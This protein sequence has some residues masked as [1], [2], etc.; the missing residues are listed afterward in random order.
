LACGQG[1]EVIDFNALFD[2]IDTD[3]DLDALRIDIADAIAHGL[4]ETRDEFGYWEKIHFAQAI[5]AF[6]WNI[7]SGRDSTSWLRLC[8]VNLERAFAPRDGRIEDYAPRNAQIETLTFEQ[9]MD[10]VRTLGGHV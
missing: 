7:N 8:L 6:A 5:S 9:L 4:R 3:N 1:G 10:G 2:R